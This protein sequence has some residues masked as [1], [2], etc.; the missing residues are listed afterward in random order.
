MI[1]N[2]AGARNDVFSVELKNNCSGGIEVL[3][4]LYS[5]FEGVA[6]CEI[7]YWVVPFFDAGYTV[8]SAIN[9]SAD[10][11]LPIVLNNLT[12]EMVITVQA[13][14]LGGKQEVAIEE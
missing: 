13:Y 3:C 11:L 2:N 6:K 8:R 9:G 14:I 7:L 1:A 4:R 10:D 5:R 12:P